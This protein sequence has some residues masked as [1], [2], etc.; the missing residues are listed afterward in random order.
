MSLSR[1]EYFSCPYCMAENDIEIDEVNDPGQT[2]IVDCQICCQPID[3]EV[4]G[5]MEDLTLVFKRDDE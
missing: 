5:M 1:I 4:H 2:L 3:V